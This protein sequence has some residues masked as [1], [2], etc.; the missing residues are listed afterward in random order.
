MLITEQLFKSVFPKAKAGIYEEISKQIERAGCKTKAQQAM[1]LAQC[2]HE[3]A[4]FTRFIENLN[5][6]TRRLLAVF[7][8]YFNTKTVA[9]FAMQ[10]ERIANRVYANRM[11]NGNEESGDGYKY[12]GRGIIQITGRDNYIKF[13][14][15]LGFDISPEQVAM[16][17]DL[18]VLTGIWYWEV[19]HLASL[20]D[21]QS[22]TKRINGGYNGLAERGALF[23]KLMK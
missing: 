13:E 20:S 7:P 4:G 3:T 6:S 2:G 10:A 14:K 18:I 22:V 19:N 15:W 21:I 9:G 5:Y 23:E 17:L 8:K 12:R 16:R 1:F 11:G